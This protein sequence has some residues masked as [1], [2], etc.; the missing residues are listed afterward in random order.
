MTH[1]ANSKTKIPA[2]EYIKILCR[3]VIIT[4]GV[5][6]I[7]GETEESINDSEMILEG[8]GVGEAIKHPGIAT[9]ALQLL[10]ASNSLVVRT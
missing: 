3:L 6:V 9:G 7:E 2:A 1:I 4:I 5:G 8:E 10:T